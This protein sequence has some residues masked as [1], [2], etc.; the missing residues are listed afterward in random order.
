MNFISEIEHPMN[1]K[2]SERILCVHLRAFPSK[3]VELTVI[4]TN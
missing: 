3:S 1:D 4:H 2:P